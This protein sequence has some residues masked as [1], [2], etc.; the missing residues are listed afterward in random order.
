MEDHTE[1]AK[2]D[3]EA[4][5]LPVRT[6]RFRSTSTHVCEQVKIAIWA[7]LIANLALCVLQCKSYSLITLMMF[8]PVTFSVC[9]DLLVVAL[10]IGDRNRF[11]L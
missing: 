1:E 4:A 10:T 9:R 7:S 5:R 6:L 2:L 11:C 3:E 8:N